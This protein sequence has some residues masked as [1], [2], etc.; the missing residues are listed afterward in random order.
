MKNHNNSSTDMPSSQNNEIGGN[1]KRWHSIKK[2]AYLE[3]EYLPEVGNIME[4]LEKVLLTVK[5]TDVP[6]FLNPNN[7]TLL[8]LAVHGKLR[9]YLSIS[10][11]EKHLRYIKFMETHPQPVDFRNLTLNS[12]LNHF[13]YR[14]EFEDPPATPNALKHE[15]KAIRFLLRC[16]GTWDDH[17]KE[18]LRTP[19]V[20]DTE[21]NVFVPFPEQVNKLYHTKYS[22]DPYENALLQTI[23]FLGFNFGMRPPGEIINLNLEDIVINE[24]GTGYIRIN[25]DKKHG[26]KRIIY[27]YNKTILSSPVFKT[28]WNYIQHWR[29]KVV[30]DK[31][32]DV[33]FLMKNGSRINGNY[34]R[35]KI[36]PIGK[37]ICNEKG[38]KLYTMRHT[39]ATYMYEYSKDIKRVS[40]LL[41]HK[42]SDTVDKYIH[43]ANF[44]KEQVGKRNLFNQALRHISK[45]GG[46]L[47][48]EKSIDGQKTVN[49]KYFLL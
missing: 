13:D 31:S 34:L 27:P 28:L 1:K 17:W 46:K 49:R 45:C 25:E 12:V 40:K 10:T 37:I 20:T 24:D 32:G 19:P 3:K 26:K 16:Y 7:S 41:G 5:R 38:F 35:K 47:D 29:P 22:D 6:L 9:Q 15:K 4:E 43:I 11:I 33:L 36:T 42:K 21:D 2:E 8:D 23:V 14:L 18:H 48:G 30:N 44:M 39:F